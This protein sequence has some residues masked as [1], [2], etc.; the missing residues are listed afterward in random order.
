MKPTLMFSFSLRRLFWMGALVCVFVRAGVA[1]ETTRWAEPQGFFENEQ[2]KRTPL[3]PGLVWIAAAGVRGGLLVETQVLDVDLQA[4]AGLRLET[5]VGASQ[6]RADSGQYFL[7]SI[8]SQMQRDSGALAVIN[9]SFFDIKSTQ[10]PS[11]LVVRGGWLLREPMLRDHPAVL[12]LADGRALIGTPGWNG[13]VSVRNK[14]GDTRA[15]REMPLAGVNRTLLQEREVVLFCPPWQR[16]PAPAAPFLRGRGAL[17]IVVR[18][19]VAAPVP[20]GDGSMSVPVEVVAVRT[21]PDRASRAL[22][23]DEMVLVAGP[24]AVDF[25][26]GQNQGQGV[27]AGAI[28]DINWRLT[29]LPAGVHTR[30]V[31]DAVSGNVILIAAG[32]LQEGGGAFWTTRH[33]RSAVGVAA[34]GRRALLVLVDGR[35]LFSAGMDLSALR[36]YL[37]HL[38][39]HDAVNLDGGGSSAITAVWKNNEVRVLNRPSDGRERLIPTAL[40]VRRQ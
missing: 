1:S 12:S 18:R 20:L 19:R 21:E 38:G 10:T 16:T 4:D 14:N 13:R 3:A 30:D 2:I 15:T 31:R 35:S 33:P 29:D 40:G 36:D 23:D 24:R 37:A 11:G 27:Q 32:R 17:E 34:D 7:R 9:A 6:A 25:F 22:A 8:P 26:Q 39:A 28:L 5:L